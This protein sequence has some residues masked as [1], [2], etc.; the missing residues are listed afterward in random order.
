MFGPT[1]EKALVFLDDKLLPSTSNAVERD[2][3][4][5]RKMQKAA[6][7]VRRTQPNLE[8][9]MAMDLLREMNGAGRERARQ[10]LHRGRSP[11][12]FKAEEQPQSVTVT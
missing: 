10:T 12:R 9:R 2:N 7:R 4:R 3:R 5:H 8:R 1:L 11:G 6:C